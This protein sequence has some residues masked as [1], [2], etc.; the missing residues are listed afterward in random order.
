ME[1]ISEVS[2][3]ERVYVLCNTREEQTNIKAQVSLLSQ[4]QQQNINIWIMKFSEFWIRDNGPHFVVNSENELGIVHH[5]FTFWGYS[6]VTSRDSQQES[7]LSQDIAETLGLEYNL[8]SDLVS[9]GGEHEFLRNKNMMLVTEHE[10]DRNP[11]KTLTE[12]TE[13]YQA[14]YSLRNFILIPNLFVFDD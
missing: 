2:A 4:I 8:I 1:I 11:N 14:L 13:E 12:I 6:P 9:E 7:L 5:K 3:Y 10:L